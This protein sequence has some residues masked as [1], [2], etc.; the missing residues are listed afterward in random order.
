ME[1]EKSPLSQRLARTLGAIATGA[2]IVGA[3]S[4]W[5]KFPGY[6]DYSASI[7][8]IFADQEAATQKAENEFAS[9]WAGFAANQ[10]ANVSKGLSAQGITDPAVKARAAEQTEGALSG[11]YAAAHAALARAKAEAGNTLAAGTAQYY[12]NLAQKQ[13]SA[14]MNKYMAEQGI[15][16][17]LGGAGASLLNM[18]K[19]EEEKGYDINPDE[20]IA[21]FPAL[22]S[23]DAQGNYDMFAPRFEELNKPMVYKK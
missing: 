6:P 4:A 12:Q 22:L 17:A 19:G 2:G 16:G 9:A 5:N 23:T 15:W 10:R 8:G 21:P 20:P 18:P 11:A 14:A 1:S 7:S 3:I 13:Y